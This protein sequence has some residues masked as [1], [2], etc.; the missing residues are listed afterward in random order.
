VTS[1]P[2]WTVFKAALEEKGFRPSRGL[3]Q[4]FLLDENMVRAIVRDSGVRPD[5]RVLEVG[6]GCGFL[7]LHLVD[8]GVDLLAVEIDERLLP[9]AE[10]LVSARG[11]ARFLRADI[12]AG[13]HA[14]APEVER[15]L[16]AEG[17]WH[18]VSNLPYSIAGP[19]LAL[20][21]A[22]PNPPATMTVLVQREVAERIAAEPG[23]RE[24]GPLSIRLQARYAP[25]ILRKVPPDL[26]W[27]RPK[28]ESAVARLVRR[29]P[30]WEAEELAS[31]DRL[32]GELLGTRRQSLGRVLGRSLGDRETARA[33]IER[34][35]IEP[36]VR[37]ETLGLE[38]WRRLIEVLRA[39]QNLEKPWE[40]DPGRV[41]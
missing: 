26:F 17:G 20:L 5:D 36:S 38:A 4:N 3:G 15:E 23:T 6:A 10:R 1:R 41:R 40:E 33:A 16:P 22:R 31:L 14:L 8:A 27:P 9:I 30:A 13:K 25:S 37:A 19:L 11:R 28:V 12:L 24:W 32:A 2:P 29:T 18:L 34:T 21:A 35:G 39:G 7:S